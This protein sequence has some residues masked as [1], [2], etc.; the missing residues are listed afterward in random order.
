MNAAQLGP[1]TPLHVDLDRGAFEPLRTQLETGIRSAIRNG[2]LA[3]GDSLPATRTLARDL[4]VSRGVVQAAYEHLIA[5]GYLLGRIGSGTIVAWSPGS[6][7]P[8]SVDP[9]PRISRALVADL[10]PN[11]PNLSHFPRAAWLRASREAVNQLP[12]HD[13]GYGDPSGLLALRTTLAHYL[14]RVRGAVVDPGNVVICSGYA[15]GLQLVL[16]AL[17][18]EGRLRLAVEDPGPDR[19]ERLRIAATGVSITS[20]PV[21]SEGIRTDLLAASAADAALVTPAHHSPTGAPLSG[22]RRRELLE[23][24]RATDGLILEDDYDSEFRYDRQP[25]RS[26]Q[27]MEPNRTFLLGTASKA[28]A[29]GLR[30][31]WIVVPDAWVAA[32]AQARRRRNRGLSSLEQATLSTFIRSGAFDTHLRAMRRLNSQRR[33]ALLS[34][35]RRHV[36]DA[37]PMGVP[38]GLSLLAHLPRAIDE[39]ALIRE[40]LRRGLLLQGWGG[41]FASGHA[42]T[43]ALVLGFATETTTRINAGVAALGRLV[44][45]S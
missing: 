37:A 41:H 14:G 34:A 9:G 36:P 40:G 8:E 26:I 2:R 7:P 22:C 43:T 21:D 42:P 30:L 38:A 3:S 33:A 10:R 15:E 1:R 28:L 29:P 12:V 13:L 39:G 44:E 24:V 23:W 45:E 17:V 6:A 35:L 5:E 18:R 25:V 19:E 4:G 27:G 11:R 31:G 20:V 16:D 32:I